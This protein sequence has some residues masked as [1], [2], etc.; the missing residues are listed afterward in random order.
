[1]SAA[2]LRAYAAPTTRI[3]LAVLWTVVAAFKVVHGP[4]IATVLGFVA[5]CAGWFAVGFS[6]ASRQGQA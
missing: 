6:V 3:V 5:M 1:M 4:W 2:I